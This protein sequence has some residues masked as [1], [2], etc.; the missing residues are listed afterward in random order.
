M[1]KDVL[2]AADLCLRCNHKPDIP[3]YSAEMRYL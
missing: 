2:Y 1:R 3:T